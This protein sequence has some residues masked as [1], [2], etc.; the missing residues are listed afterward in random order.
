MSMYGAMR[1]SE[2][3]SRSNTSATMIRVLSLHM[4]ASSIQLY[5]ARICTS[6]AM[7]FS[8][9]SAVCRGIRTSTGPESEEDPDAFV[10]PSL[11]RK[12]SLEAF[13]ARAPHQLREAPAGWELSA[14]DLEEVDRWLSLRNKP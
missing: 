5:S 9:V 11:L 12:T 2:P 1:D 6:L 3:L 14:F 7:M 8:A 4:C 10:R 13:L